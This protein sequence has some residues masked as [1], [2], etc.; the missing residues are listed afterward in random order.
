MMNQKL[1]C[2]AFVGVDWADEEH[3]F[4][5]LPADGGAAATRHVEATA[6]GHRRLG[7][8]TAGA[9]RRTDG[10]RLSGAIARALIYALMSYEFLALCPLNPGNS[11]PDRRPQVARNCACGVPSGPCPPA[12]ARRS[13]A[14][15]VWLP[16]RAGAA[17]GR[18]GY[19][20]PATGR[21]LPLRHRTAGRRN[22]LE[23][24]PRGRNERSGLQRAAAGGMQQSSAR[25][26]QHHLFGR[27]GRQP[28]QQYDGPRHADGFTKHGRMLPAR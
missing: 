5:V 19:R 9:I 17:C 20:S 13:G 12:Q 7:R 16:C 21:P 24:L 11:P 3:A 15:P 26:A 8:R 4:C 22:H 6:R 18:R 10:G 27:C 14:G 28:G 1:D 25:H 23:R 2:A